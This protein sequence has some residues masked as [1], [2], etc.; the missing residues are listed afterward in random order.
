[1]TKNTKFIDLK[2]KMIDCI[3]ENEINFKSIIEIKV[4]KYND[5]LCTLTE[6]N[7][8]KLQTDLNFLLT[9][10]IAENNEENF[11]KIEKFIEEI[12]LNKK[13]SNSDTESINSG[14]NSNKSIIKEEIHLTQL[15]IEN[16]YKLL[17][18]YAGANDVDNKRITTTIK[19]KDIDTGKISSKEVKIYLFDAI[20]NSIIRKISITREMSKKFDTE[21][22]KFV[23]NFRSYSKEKISTLSEYNEKEDKYYKIYMKRKNSRKIIINEDIEEDSREE[24]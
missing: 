8:K 3:V 13:L 5:E 15:E 11:D 7:S 24:E 1:M 17:E 18:N 4:K 2:N 19:E 6:E 22:M 10:W 20:Y 23:D 9:N 14:K 16:F 12:K 21:Y